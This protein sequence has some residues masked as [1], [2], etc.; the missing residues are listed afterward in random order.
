MSSDL[1]QTRVAAKQFYIDLRAA[2][3]T[4]AAWHEA[5]RWLG[6]NDLFYLLT[7]ILRRPDLDHP[8][9]FDRIR[10]I[11]AE[12]DNCID[13]WAREHG[14]SSC[15]TFGLT[16]MDILNDPEITIGIFS[17][18]RKIAKSFLLQIMRE[19]ELNDH[20]K[21]LYPDVLYAN[22]TRESPQWAVD[23]GIVV[24]RRGNP[25]EPTIEAAG[26][27]DSQPTGRHYMLRIYDDTVTRESVATPDQI[28]KTTD[29]WSLSENLGVQAEKGGRVR[30]IG[31]RYSLHDTY[32]EII[33]RGAAKP[34]LFPATHNGRFDGEPVFFSQAEWEKRLRNQSRSTVAAQLLQNPLADQ[35]ATFRTSWLK[36]WEVRPRTINVY[37]MMDPSMGRNAASDNTAIAVVGV[38]A[39][40][41]KY[42]LDGFCHRMSLSERWVRLKETY[43]KWSRMNG[44]QHVSVGVE[45]YGMQADIAYFEERMMQERLHFSIMELNWSRDSGQSKTE[46][47]SRLEPDFRNG[48]MFLPG[49]VFKEGRE[50]YWRVGTNPN[51]Q[52]DELKLDEIH[53]YPSRGQTSLQMRHIASGSADLVATPLMCKD[54][55]GRAYDLTLTLIEEYASFP[56]G[57][58]KD[59]IDAVSRIYDLY[60]TGPTLTS[61]EMTEERVF[62][63]A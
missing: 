12:P 38:A 27:V 50:C 15:I 61:A 59:L 48:R 8:W 28:A 53:Y 33:K 35:S 21:K 40:G 58:L 6:R 49:V 26:L 30:Y 47:V 23:E 51:A 9:L 14:K 41:A 44:V 55:D 13:L 42:F 36:Q 52:D 19:F 2:S 43:K 18:T 10:M 29:A 31:T 56:F 24:K 3:T 39:G 25:K 11:Q 5:E 4:A 63:D 45:R 60:P 7:V 1:P 46:R 22:P 54:G 37:I 17:H 32:S 62:W 16:I 57:R 34:R 20:L